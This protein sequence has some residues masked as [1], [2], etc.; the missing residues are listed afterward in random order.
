VTAYNNSS[1]NWRYDEVKITGT[2]TPE[3]TKSGGRD[4]RRDGSAFTPQ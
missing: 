3:S 1:G 4:A 2:A